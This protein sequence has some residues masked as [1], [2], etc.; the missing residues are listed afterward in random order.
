MDTSTRAEPS[1]IRKN[2]FPGSP[3]R[4]STVPAGSSSTSVIRATA[5]SCLCEHPSSSVTSSR[6]AILSSCVTRP[7]K[8]RPGSPP[9]PESRVPSRMR[10]TISMAG[11][12]HP[13]AAPARDDRGAGLLSRLGLQA[14][15]EVAVRLGVDDLVE[16]GAVAGH[17]AHAGDLHVPHAPAILARAVHQIFDRNLRLVARDD[18]GLDDGLIA[19]HGIGHDDHLLAV[20]TIHASQVGAIDQLG[21]EANE[22][23]TLLGATVLPVPSEGALGRL[24]EVE[25]LVGDSAHGEAALG[26]LG[27]E[28][29]VLKVG[30][31]PL[32]AL[33]QLLAW[34]GGESGTRGGQDDERHEGCS[35]HGAGCCHGCDLH[36]FVCAREMPNHEI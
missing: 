17:Q 25:Q 34:A 28:V 35:K 23:L 26:L 4:A 13:M 20:V 5:R 1:T 29:G 11:I 24:L 31:H 7:S 22:F 32:N 14:L 6:R 19:F 9:P 16:L 3:A 27:L 12:L 30:E 36:D 2:S 10:L 18:A 15:D 8:N 21:E 33:I